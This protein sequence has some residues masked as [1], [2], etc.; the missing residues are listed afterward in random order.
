MNGVRY[1][2]MTTNFVWTKLE[3]T[4]MDMEAMWFQQD[5]ANCHT[6]NGTLTLLPDKFNG[7]VISRSG[8][9]N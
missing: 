2:E 6:T 8:N 3:D 9:V 4:D 7:V 5:A 1:H